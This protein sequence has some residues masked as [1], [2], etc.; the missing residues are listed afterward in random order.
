MGE[1]QGAVGVQ[2]VHTEPLTL[3]FSGVHFQE[4]EEDRK[5]AE[6]EGVAVTAPRKGRSVEKENVAVGTVSARPRWGLKRTGKGEG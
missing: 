2:P 4:I 5:K 6:L 3:P 1:V